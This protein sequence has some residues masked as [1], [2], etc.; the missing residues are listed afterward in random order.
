MA[1][2]FAISNFGLR[3]DCQYVGVVSLNSDIIVTTKAV[4]RF[5]DYGGQMFI[6]SCEPS[7]GPLYLLHC[8]RLQY[9]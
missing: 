6:V 3:A 4:L 9:M 7:P 1:H 2:F 5:Q 8:L